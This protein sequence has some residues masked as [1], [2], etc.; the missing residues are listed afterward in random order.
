MSILEQINNSTSE[1]EIIKLVE[2]HVLDIET[3]LGWLEE[4]DVLEKQGDTKKA[5]LLRAAKK[6]YSELENM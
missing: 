2:E 3:S 4:A 6:R 5:E 1:E